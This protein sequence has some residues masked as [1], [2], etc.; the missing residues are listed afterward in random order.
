V[1]PAAYHIW[2]RTGTGLRLH[3]GPAGVA[4]GDIP[5]CAQSVKYGHRL[6]FI[7]GVLVGD[8]NIAPLEHDVWSHKPLLSMVSHTP[9]QTE[10][11]TAW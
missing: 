10:R 7:R 1:S 2:L 6:D 5:D 9:P 3:A 8:L 11:L 4:G